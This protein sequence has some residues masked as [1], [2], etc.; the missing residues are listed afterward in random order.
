MMLF[1]A[2]GMICELRDGLTTRRVC[3]LR[4]SRMA[5]TLSAVKMMDGRGRRERYRLE[6]TRCIRHRRTRHMARQFRFV[7]PASKLRRAGCDMC[8]KKQNRE[9]RCGVRLVSFQYLHF[10]IRVVARAPR[11]ADAPVCGAGVKTIVCETVEKCPQGGV[12]AK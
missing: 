6:T 11:F 7:G 9:S 1:F 2:S 8:R 5:R 10:P 4:P 12:I 3:V